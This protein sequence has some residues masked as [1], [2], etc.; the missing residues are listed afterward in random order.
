[1]KLSSISLE[2]ILP[3][4]AIVLAVFCLVCNGGSMLHP[5]LW[6]HEKIWF[7]C[8]ETSTSIRFKQTFDFKLHGTLLRRG[9]YVQIFSQY[10]IYSTFEMPAMSTSLR[11]FNRRH[12]IPFRGFSSPFLVRSPHLVEYCNVRFSSSYSL[13]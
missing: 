2:S 13:V 6:I 4:H 1:M 7:Y 8:G 9:F 5:W 12:S 11:T 3:F 10:V